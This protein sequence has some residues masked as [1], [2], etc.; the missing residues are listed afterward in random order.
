MQS[1]KLKQKIG[2]V[3]FN[4]QD[5]PSAAWA[6]SE[7][8][9]P[10]YISGPNDLNLNTV[11][12]S[13]LTYRI[14]QRYSVSSGVSLYSNEYISVSLSEIYSELDLSSLSI[15]RA[16]NVLA[17]ICNAVSNFFSIY[18]GS[19]TLPPA[20]LYSGIK[21][22]SGI[23]QHPY[24]RSISKHLA[25]AHDSLLH[26]ISSGEQVGG[27]SLIF[28]RF[29]YARNVLNKRIP[30]GRWN[31]VSNL[32]TTMSMKQF[33]NWIAQL[34]RPALICLSY[35]ESLTDSLFRE[36]YS[37]TLWMSLEEFQ[38]H[39]CKR[40]A[41]I[42]HVLVCDGYGKNPI[43]IPKWGRFSQSSYSF[44]VFCQNL[45]ASLLV[46]GKGDPLS[47]WMLCINRLNCYQKACELEGQSQ[48]NVTGYGL[49]RLTLDSRSPLSGNSVD[50]ALKLNLISHMSANGSGF[51]RPVPDAP[52]NI[53]IM[54]IAMER[55]AL[56]FLQETDVAAVVK[57]QDSFESETSYIY[58]K[59]KSG[60]LI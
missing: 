26:G 55:G 13:N 23:N 7:G 17:N 22:F 19:S 57:A 10:N 48:H 53:D 1:G 47:V 33:D 16:I 54:Q 52:T 28:H 58:Q 51:I 24:S 25:S 41:T 42:K 14:S 59:P 21:R 29:E 37:S 30:L 5:E 46:G 31:D 2:V 6:C 38:V 15:H 56:D 3:L 11:W 45:W 18:S 12:I 39:G 27:T 9:K 44:G 50:L 36:F 20:S 40:Q 43:T 4:N 34:Q 35:D 60:F 49:G 8:E 32:V